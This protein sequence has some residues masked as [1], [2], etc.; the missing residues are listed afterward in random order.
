[1]GCDG[2]EGEGG[3]EGGVAVGGATTGGA[4]GAATAGVTHTVRVKSYC[5]SVSV[6]YFAFPV[7]NE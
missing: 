2:W 6:H 3:G 4:G 1:M 7:S 5:A